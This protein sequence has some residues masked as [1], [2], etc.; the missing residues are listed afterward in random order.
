M[1]TQIAKSETL[2][3]PPSPAGGPRTFK[4]G[5]RVR[6]RAGFYGNCDGTITTVEDTG[7]GWQILEI[8]LGCRWTVKESNGGVE[9]CN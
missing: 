6:I 5:D 9:L 7:G 1:S 8:N 2:S 3:A 4:T